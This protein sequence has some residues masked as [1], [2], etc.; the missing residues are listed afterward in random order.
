M[1]S[2]TKPFDLSEIF[3]FGTRITDAGELFSIEKKWKEHETIYCRISSERGGGR[4]FEVMAV[5]EKAGDKYLVLTDT[6]DV[7][8]DDPCITGLV[9]KLTSPDSAITILA[10]E[11]EH[12]SQTCMSIVDLSSDERN[13][14][15]VEHLELFD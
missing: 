13:Q 6:P 2:I 5:I 4:N 14:S 3:M 8:I 1:S 11:L 9:L 12:V 10:E 15:A 7:S